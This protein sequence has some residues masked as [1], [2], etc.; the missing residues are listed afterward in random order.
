MKNIQVRGSIKRENITS[1]EL[2][3]RQQDWEQKGKGAWGEGKAGEVGSILGSHADNIGLRQKRSWKPL[4]YFIKWYFYTY[5]KMLIS[6]LRLRLFIWLPLQASN[7]IGTLAIYFLNSSQKRVLQVW[8]SWK[9]PQV[10]LV[11]IISKHLRS[12]DSDLVA[13]R[14]G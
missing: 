6:E 7:R 2:E 8:W 1:E 5:L 4:K 12:K 3:S 13:D 14:A 10:P 9:I 11:F